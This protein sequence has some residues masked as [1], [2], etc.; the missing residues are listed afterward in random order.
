MDQA[1]SP[2]FFKALKVL[3]PGPFRRYMMGETTSS[4]G[5]WMQMM[6]QTWVMTDLTRS[7]FMLGLVSFAAGIPMLALAMV[8]GSFA[9]RHDKRLILL[10]TQVVQIVLAVAMGYLVWRHQIQLWHILAIALILGASN[11]FEM[12]A[13]SAMVPELVAPDEI[14][15]AIAIDRSSFHATRLVGPA[16][17]GIAIGAWGE[18]SAFFANA[19]SF[20]AL[21]LALWSI[22]P[23]A[24]GTAEEEA[25]RQGGMKDGIAYVRK[26]KP[27]LAMIALMAIQTFFVFPLLT[28]LMPLYAR[29]AIQVGPQ[30]M[31]LLMAV[32]GVGSLTGSIGMLGIH[33]NKRPLAIGLSAAGI[34]VAIVGLAIARHLPLAA[35]SLVVM[36]ICM[37]TVI[38]LAN[39][40]VMERAP[41]YLRGRVSAIA[42]LSFFGLMPFSALGVTGLSDWIGM[43]PAMLIAA[44]CFGISAAYVVLG[45]ARRAMA[46]PLDQTEINQASSQV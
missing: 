32:S 22:H 13:A 39:T 46:R 15:S 23:R 36:S 31:G 40:T 38:G 29:D 9:D 16:L 14:A 4:V 2:T 3:R 11:A 12:P 30:G 43:R 20:L 42:G 17:A 21:I 45:P 27:T 5:T 44:A 35:A 25:K 10:V 19:F 6:A 1:S 41:D 37:S 26:D 7:A 34:T 28:V 8:G 18:A 24:R 33:S